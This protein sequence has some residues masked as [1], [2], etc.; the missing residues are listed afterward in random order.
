[1]S[2]NQAWR[3][4]RIHFGAVQKRHQQLVGGEG[5]KIGQ[6]CRLIVLKN[7][8][9]GGGGVKNPEKL[10]SLFM[11]APFAGCK[12]LAAISKESRRYRNASI[13]LLNSC[14]Q[15]DYNHCEHGTSTYRF[16]SPIELGPSAFCL[17]WSWM[18]KL[19]RFLATHRTSRNCKKE[20][21][22]HSISFLSTMQNLERQHVKK[23][24]A[25]LW[26]KIDEVCK[27]VNL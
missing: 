15:F 1:M 2:I 27:T 25:H 14:I 23:R 20:L 4:L 10:P 26:T 3:R 17:E 11:D 5:S 16:S 13:K 9:Q 24:F 18:Q 6:N 12:S 21:L 8:W 22:T 19:S 7:C